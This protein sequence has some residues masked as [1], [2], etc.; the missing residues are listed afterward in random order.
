[1][2]EWMVQRD[3]SWLQFNYR[4]LQEAMDG[5]VP[6]YE[7]I[8]FLAIYSS[9]MDEFFRV[10]VAQHRNLMRMSKKT[11]RELDYDPK[12]LVRD[13]SLVVTI[14]REYFNKIFNDQIIPQLKKHKI[15]IKRR[16]ELN[17][18]QIPFVED[19][20]HANLLPYVQPVLLVKNKIRP[21]LNEGALYLT[22][23]LTDKLPKR[24]SGAPHYDYA[25]VKIPSDYCPRF[26]VLPSKT[27]KKDLIFL[28]DVV[29]HNIT[30]LFP[31]YDIVDTFSIKLTRDAELY[32]DD[33]FSGNLISKI[34]ESLNKRNVGPAARLI[35]DKSMP[36][37]LLEFLQSSF[38][39]ESTD[40]M[41]EGR[42]HNNHDLFHFPNFAKDR[43][44]Y[45]SIPPLTYSPLQEAEDFF[46]AISQ[47]DHILHFPY[48]SYQSVVDFFDKAAKDPQVTH[49]KITQYRVAKKSRIMNA[50]I[51]AAKAGKHVSVFVEVKARFDEEANLKWGEL[52]EKSGI[53]VQYSFPGLKVHSKIAL[54]RRVIDSKAELYCYFS[55]GNFNEETAKFY[56]DIGLFTSRQELTH[57]CARLFSFLETVKLPDKKFQHLLVG[58]FNLREGLTELVLREIDQANMGK[59]SGIVL[60]MNSLQDD[61][62]IS[63][64]YQA[65]KAGVKIKLIIRGICCLVPGVPHL[66]ENI[67]AIS[68]VDR[69]LEH[70]RVF[71]FENGGEKKVYISSADW[72]VRNLSYRIESCVPIYDEKIKA[73]ILD[74]VNIQLKDNTKARIIRMDNNNEF[75]KNNNDI[76]IR[77]QFEIYHYLRRLAEPPTE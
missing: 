13:I 46:G 68:I 21:F 10:R 45:P 64:L 5:S 75:V 38:E 9:N 11:Q 3:L 33:E 72:M 4:V 62:M 36:T 20:F 51:E 61:K 1:M 15:Y 53:Q 69:Y 37:H 76:A 28:D 8:K 22:V 55:T 40:L 58:Q 65:S 73:Q 29:R 60:K 18:E 27:G 59:P 17:E 19:Y 30:Y 34:K 77:S 25:I 49:I 66:S 2:K 24:K 42:Y 74:V 67:E 7:R 47:G 63:L 14:Q 50:L 35:Y 31:G 12:Q 54:V 16:L 43:L 26:I 71:I 70:A 6:L 48:Q 41:P 32:I 39:I 52:L 56:G 57:E 44:L 23:I